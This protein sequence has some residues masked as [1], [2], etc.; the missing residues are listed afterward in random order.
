MNDV[1]N[2]RFLIMEAVSENRLY[3]AVDTATG[4]LTA[5]K[6]WIEDDGF[7]RAEVDALTSL[8][9]PDIPQIICTFEEEGCKYIAEEWLEGHALKQFDSS[10]NIV[11]LAVTLA[12]FV[13]AISSKTSSPRT[14]GDIRPSNLI[15]SDG[16]IYF[17]DF[18][19]SLVIDKMNKKAADE[20]IRVTDKYFTAPEV[21]YGKQSVQSDIYSIGA[22]IEWLLGGVDDNGINLSCIAIDSRL[23]AIIKKCI[24]YRE[25]DRYRDAEELIEDLKYIKS[26]KKR[27]VIKN[28][29]PQNKCAGS[30]SVYVDCN[31]F[32]SW[33]MATAAAKYFGM[34]TC[35][36][37][38][39]DR[40]QKKLTY[41]ADSNCSY[42]SERV[43]DETSPYLYSVEPLFAR[44]ADSWQSKGLLNNVPEYGDKMFYSGSRFPG[45]AEPD[46]EEF[47]ESLI[48]W[49]KENFDC[50]LFVTDRY[51]DK[52]V[53]KRFSSICDFTIAT[54]FANI[55]D[56]EACKDYYER[57]GG[58]V[59]YAAWE[60]NPRTSLPEESIKMMVGEDVYLGAI[61]HSEEQEYKKNFTSKIQPIFRDEGKDEKSVYIKIINGLFQIMSSNALDNERRFCE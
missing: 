10:E 49:A 25:T 21:F 23:K 14:H 22:V 4:K 30:F 48:K 5:I 6:K 13:S 54:P 39:T 33:E 53:V 51:D 57:F 3:K 29:L 31:V 37:A 19:C 43:E 28:C 8:K 44:N 45:E 55:D 32:F 16:K 52:P 18:E 58:K 11:D 24:S 59:L 50:T 42:G 34:K 27:S 41:Y 35:I 36:M 46:K 20:T 26:A 2:G 7:Y 56:I 15:V 1:L 12:E 60:F 38:L 47:V 61:T 40:T 9:H 17:I